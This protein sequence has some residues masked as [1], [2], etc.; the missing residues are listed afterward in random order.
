MSKGYNLRQ[1]SLRQIQAFKAFVETGTV[2]KAADL[3]FISQPA[4]SKLLTHL[5]Q[6][7]GLHLLDR[8]HGKMNVTERGMRLYDEI[9]RVFSGVDQIGQAIETIRQED[10]GHLTIG[11][12]PAIPATLV[13][14]ATKEFVRKYP[15]V[16]LSFHI[17]SS[18]FIVDGI[19][20]RKFDFGIA[21]KPLDHDQ[22]TS[23]VLD[24]G[25]HIA[26][27]PANHK[28]AKKRSLNVGDLCSHP[29]IGYSKSSASRHVLERLVLSHELSL[30]VVLEATTANTVIE[31][32]AQ[33]LGIA[34]VPPI[35]YTTEIEGVK[36]IPLKDKLSLPIYVVR[37]V[38]SRRD[39]IIDDFL[40]IFG[41]AL[42]NAKDSVQ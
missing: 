31:L 6:D 33:G 25:P 40:A 15:D 1:P 39:A 23:T 12:M 32:V 34:V 27:V 29:L 41:R 38:S 13:A 37:A 42:K 21:L 26:V 7:T 28:L 35:Q 4:A 30:N 16:Y 20:A 18:Q 9:D 22:F 3:L 14:Q 17:R 10:R 11:L 36:F 5:E 8:G 24:D 19:L 2:S